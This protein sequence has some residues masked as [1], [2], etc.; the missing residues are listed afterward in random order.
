MWQCVQSYYITFDLQQTLDCDRMSVHV[1]LSSI[2]VQDRGRVK[3]LSHT[4]R[5]LL[6]KVESSL[7]VWGIASMA[8]D[9]REENSK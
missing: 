2:L 5:G 3:S 4:Y 1:I 9:E 7:W 8:N 6:V